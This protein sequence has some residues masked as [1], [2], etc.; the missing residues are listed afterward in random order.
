MST[1]NFVVLF[2][3][4][5][6]CISNVFS[7]NELNDA[8]IKAGL[9]YNISEQVNWKKHASTDVFIIGV[10]GN[11]PLMLKAIKSIESQQI[12]GRRVIVNKFKSLM[13]IEDADVLYLNYSSNFETNRIYR[14][15]KNTNT[16]FIT[17]RNELKR[18]TMINFIH[19]DN[20]K[21]SFEVN[22]KNINE[23]NI[24]IN[25]KLLLLGGTELDIRELY[26]KTE[27]ELKEEQQKVNTISHQLKEKETEL[28][29]RNNDL[30]LLE[31]EISKRNTAIRS[32]STEITHHES[33]VAA[34]EKTLREQ[35]TT[36]KKR[37]KSIL[38][39]N[40]QHNKLKTNLDRLYLEQQKQLELVKNKSSHI[41]SLDSLILSK[42]YVINSQGK[43]I[44]NQE[45]IIHAKTR[46]VY[47]L[48]ILGALMFIL[49]LISIWAYRQKKNLSKVLKHKVNERT[50][51]LL[52]TNHNLESEILKRKKY[53]LELI[54][55]ERNYREIFNS[56]SDAVFIFDLSGNIIDVNLSMLEMY[57]YEI[58]E[59]SKFSFDKLSSNSQEFSGSKMKEY[60]NHAINN[61]QQSLEWQSIS[62]NGKTFWI[63]IVLKKA[64]IGDEDRVLCLV[65]NINER[66]TAQLEL[67]RYRKNL[68]NM[69]EQRTLE[70]QNSKENL[71]VANHELEA[72]N[73]EIHAANEELCDQ[74]E[75]L[76]SNN[77]ELSE[78]REELKAT[79]NKLKNTQHR[80]VESEKMASV[81]LIASGVAHEINNPLNFIQ[82]GVMALKMY[83]EDKNDTENEDI[84]IVLS[85][86]ETG[87]RRA[88]KIVKSLNLFSRKTESFDEECD[89]HDIINNSLIML[90]NKI[91]GQIEILK[92]F[93]PDRIVLKGNTGKL[94]QV[95]LNLLTN[96]VQAI[97]DKGHIEIST[98]INNNNIFIAIKD[99][100]HGI[101]KDIINKITDPFFTTKEAGEGTGLGLAIVKNIVAEH[102]GEITITSENKKGAEI[103][104]SLPLGI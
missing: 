86:I 66:K 76:E 8:D 57:R 58:P 42:E 31:N 9:I 90:E 27:K 15:I 30:K 99:S 59:L 94:H 85:G 93:S 33:T 41:S 23:E 100:G 39:K 98:Q 49:I 70:L 34:R 88:A 11:D 40:E 64:T 56:V 95:F 63:E 92:K 2:F 104:I 97:V 25:P 78:Q 32:L 29:K 50:K 7:Q 52:L 37:D 54:K 53:E 101:N 16:L 61:G 102:N 75:M 79:I 35:E 43:H 6:Y 62:K 1:R 80:L 71:E 28:Q 55:S 44:N 65:R 74:R 87:V 91:K 24:N 36:I 18:Q 47:L 3:C 60:F 81:G 84:D 67:D 26:V 4:Y 82:G 12:K 10:Y 45:D 73:E 22:R 38:R 48:V 5:F 77:K 69:V 14:L 68:E 46:V 96:A 20:G 83:F 19:H 103:N 51:E 72:S 13:D 89:I 21:I 17:D